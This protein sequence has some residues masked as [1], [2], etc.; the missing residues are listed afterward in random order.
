MLKYKNEESVCVWCTQFMLL[1]FQDDIILSLFGIYLFYL[2]LCQNEN[3]FQKAI[4]NHTNTHT[5]VLI[6]ENA[7]VAP[8]KGVPNKNFTIFKYYLHFFISTKKQ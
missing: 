3:D 5:M 8:K 4:E 1:C 6:P 7:E 2:P